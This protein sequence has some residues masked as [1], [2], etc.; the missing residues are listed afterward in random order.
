MNDVLSG[1]GY[2]A[3]FRLRN[4]QVKYQLIEPY[5]A[6]LYFLYLDDS[7]KKISQLLEYYNLSHI[8]Y[9]AVLT[10]IGE[11]LDQIYL[12]DFVIA[13]DTWLS[14]QPPS[15]TDR[16]TDYFKN[17]DGGWRSEILKQNAYIEKLAAHICDTTLANVTLFLQR[18]ATDTRQLHDVFNLPPPSSATAI[19]ILGGDRHEN[20]QQPVLLILGERRIIYKPRDSSVES[21]LNA[22]CKIV[23]IEAVCPKT[24]SCKTHLWQD[25]VGNRPLSSLDKALDTY[26]Q[27]GEILA[28][29][30]MLNI[31]DCHFDNFIVDEH[32]VFLIDAETSFQ[33]FFEDNPDFERSVYQSG[34]LQ[35]PEVA[36]NG[37][38]H[39]SALTAVTNIFQSYTYPHALNDAS[40]RIQVRYERGFKK[41]TQNYP[42][43]NGKPVQSEKYILDVISGYEDAYSKFMANEEAVITFLGKH[44]EIRPRYL[45]RTTAYYMLVINK[46]IHPDVSRSID[47]TFQSLVDEF[48]HYQGAHHRFTALIPY[49]AQSLI[50]YDVPIF[51]IRCNSTS[52]FSSHGEII[53]NFFTQPPL[54]QIKSNFMRPATYLSRQREL[55]ARSMHV[56]LTTR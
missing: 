55:I 3:T 44:D 16:Y 11:T 32:R 4:T 51:Y 9:S 26:R 13:F 14:T 6:Y 24:L 46:I 39:T 18:L 1:T 15:S 36:M 52:L 27:Y 23:G 10:H 19:E 45:I 53:N 35:S 47:S 17:S 7:N 56:H 8:D 54:E 5:R 49:E 41:E 20:G 29:A 34:L 30:D 22:V 42:H 43:F 40:E 12:P 48:L 37:I 31:N 25:Y 21:V 33:Y 38:G 50:N 2:S 28:L